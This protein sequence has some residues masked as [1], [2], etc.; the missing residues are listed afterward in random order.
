MV[1]KEELKKTIIKMSF[2][3]SPYPIFYILFAFSLSLRERLLAS[4][5]IKFLPL[6]QL[7]I[8]L[9]PIHPYLFGRVGHFKWRE[10]FSHLLVFCQLLWSM[11]EWMIFFSLAFFPPVDF[12][13]FQHTKPFFHQ[14]G[15]VS[16]NGWRKSNFLY[17]YFF[18]SLFFVWWNG[19]HMDH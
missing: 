12:V 17:Y 9:V 6:S 1:C 3:F 2:F 19:S 16:L 15:R 10:N 7:W 13:S 14:V 11:C 5:R 8:S 4:V 18:N